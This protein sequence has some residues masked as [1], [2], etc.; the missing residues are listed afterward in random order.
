MDCIKDYSEIQTESSA[1]QL[2]R[3]QTQ[4]ARKTIESI[5]QTIQIAT[6]IV[7]TARKTVGQI[8]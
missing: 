3:L 2:T 6:Q 7:Y 4:E 1:K 5:G 8:I